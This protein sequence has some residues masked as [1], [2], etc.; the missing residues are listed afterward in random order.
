MTLRNIQMPLCFG[1]KM[2]RQI[3]ALGLMFQIE[4][5][6]HFW[7]TT[8]QVELFA[9]F[10]VVPPQA[11][12]LEITIYMKKNKRRCSWRRSLGKSVITIYKLFAK[13]LFTI[14]R[15]KQLC[16]LNF[17]NLDN[18]MIWN[19]CFADYLLRPIFHFFLN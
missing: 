10:R 7:Q 3:K 8:F 14:Y 19:R 11:R 16:Q 5:T 1:Y 17:L 13:T 15:A 18:P 4:F 9:E 6:T 2:N 12:Q